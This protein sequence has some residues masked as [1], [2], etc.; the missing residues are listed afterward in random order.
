MS[1]NK[2]DFNTILL[3]I[4]MGMFCTASSLFAL[5]YGM[6]KA[7][8]NGCKQ[9]NRCWIKHLKNNDIDYKKLKPSGKEYL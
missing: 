5:K 7:Y 8:K 9:T 2:R 1:I 6:D 4:L 3:M